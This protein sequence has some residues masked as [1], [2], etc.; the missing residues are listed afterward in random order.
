[1]GFRVNVPDEFRREAGEIY[2]YIRKHGPADP[3]KWFLGLEKELRSLEEFADW[4][5]FAP[6]NEYAREEILQILYGPF[7]ILYVLRGAVAYVL[8]IRHGAR[9]FL[10]KA[11][12]DRLA[13]SLS[14]EPDEQA[15]E[16]NG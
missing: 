6:E 4:K 16:N 11:Q 5:S 7:R 8:T 15:E 1:M 12:I 14:R 13:E 9:R 2:E 3:D 10:S